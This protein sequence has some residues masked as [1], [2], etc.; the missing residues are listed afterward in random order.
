MIVC[1]I[2]VKEGA[3]GG[4]KVV[5]SPEQRD[6]TKV[7]MMAAGV[8]DKGVAAALEWLTVTY[9][10]NDVRV[11]AGPGIEDYCREYVRQHA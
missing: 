2:I 1:T 5:M 8:V 9:C 3:D 7:E 10:Q 4:V 11:A 6:A